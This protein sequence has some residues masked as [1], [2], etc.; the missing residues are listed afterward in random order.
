M[1][2]SEF[3]SVER[4]EKTQHYVVPVFDAD[5]GAKELT[6]RGFDEVA[7]VGRGGFGTVFRARQQALD[8]T[9][10]IKILS[11]DLD[12]ESRDRFFREQQAMGRLSGHP[13]IV[14]VFEVGVTDSD[15]PY[16]VMPYHR[17]DSLGRQIR[18]SGPLPWPD[19]VR[20]AIKM[21]GALET[22]HRIGTLHR[23]VKPANILLNDYG[24]P[25]L[26]DFGIARVSGGF[27]TTTGEITGSPAY[28][29]PE[30]LE[31]RGASVAADIYGL[32]ATLFCLVTG[33]A[34]VER[35]EGESVVAQFIR[36]AH[37]PTQELHR[38]D[39]PD[40][41]CSAIEHA[42]AREP[43]GRPRTALDVGREL[44]QV[45][46]R[47]GLAVTDMA[48]PDADVDEP[49][50]VDPGAVSGTRPPTTST[51]TP[52]GAITKYRPPFNPRRL[53]QRQRL[54]DTLRAGS[55]RRLVLIHAPAGFGKSTLAA[56]WRDTLI[57]EGVPVAWL[58]I[59]H[60]DNNVVWFLTHLLEALHLVA[61]SVVASSAQVLEEG[62]EEAQRYV[63]SS[64]INRIHSQRTFVVVVIDDWHR[65]SDPPTIAALELLLDNGCHHL[66]LIITSR[67]QQNLPITRLRL[68]DE[69]IEIDS[70][71]L[72]FDDTESSKFLVGFGGLHLDEHEI[73]ELNTTTEGWA[74]ALQLVSL[75]LRGRAD[76]TTIIRRM[77]GRHRGV[78]DYLTENVLSTLDSQ[79]LDF[80]LDTC[81]PER[82][83][84]E[85]AEALSGVPDGAE[86]LEDIEAQDLFLH[87]IDDAGEW[88]RYHHMF[89]NFLRRRLA[90]DQP[91]RLRKL[92]KTASTWFVEHGMLSEAVD[93]A[94]AAG[95]SDRAMELVE[96]HS[97]DLIERSRLGT[98]LRLLDKLPA[99]QVAARPRLQLD[100]AWAKAMLV[101]PRREE[102][103]KLLA[104]VEA[105][106]PTADPRTARWQAEAK[107][108]EAVRAV[109]VDD[110]GSIAELVDDAL[111]HADELPPR[112]VSVAANV[113]TLSSVYRFRFDAA[114]R[115]QIWARPYHRRNYGPFI[116]VFGHCYSGMAAWE[117]LQVGEAEHEFRA[118]VQLAYDGGAS[119]SH[120]AR[121]AS[122]MLGELRY[123]LGD[124][125]EAESLLDRSHEL[126]TEGGITDFML[127]TLGTGARLKALLGDEEAARARLAEGTHAA[128]EWGTPRLAARMW[129]ERV[130]LGW[131]D[132]EVPASGAAATDANA[133]VGL[134]YELEEQTA[135]R[136][137]LE[138]DAAADRSTAVARS[139]ALLDRIRANR[140]PK[141]ELEAF[142]L[143]ASCLAAAGDSGAAA[144]ELA[145]AAAR[146]R[147]LGLTQLLLDAGWHTREALALVDG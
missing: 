7:E 26:T 92:Q 10:A 45:E 130:R 4:T 91:E 96:E 74:A 104:G 110:I 136:A 102:M 113:D 30:V 29:A 131:L 106:D 77:S 37:S 61:P 83:C 123:A 98:L 120:A 95:D 17:R 142:I 72:R 85:L 88:F 43:D 18:T 35:R 59:D 51:T 100:R 112:V 134:T 20:V 146:C 19:A 84:G 66:Q 126:G 122:A 147:D 78:S 94:L 111:D 140:R 62:G 67:S 73:A 48:I 1:A 121:L 129:N 128:T 6:A 107:V 93:H 139:A 22:A 46:R 31:G 89:A 114:R 137:L 76:P 71:A 115:R 33:H 97:P 70:G 108:I 132:G 82:I 127:A 65:V 64:L 50:P 109:T 27:E 42:M 21:A 57:A 79:T 124:L 143:H 11:T 125:R 15:R 3:E 81:V 2:D 75:S 56:Q 144:Q 49:P 28:T 9:V 86:M 105:L 23:D 39:L 47:H 68:A 14:H 12:P 116:Q 53:V 36:I 13:N 38:D 16:L 101:R 119:H 54:I 117:Q 135:I 87:R 80:V 32:G 103:R 99:G 5:L 69:L 8:R 60:D 145:P 58:S 63:L 25:Q 55:R 118:G 138:R 90:R 44:R 24:E 133:I 52:P 141:A 41:L 40:D 34:A